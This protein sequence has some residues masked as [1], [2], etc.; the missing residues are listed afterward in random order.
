MDNINL[1]KNEIINMVDKKSDLFK[2]L[3]EFKKYI[4][5]VMERD[6][7]NIEV[8]Y[9]QDLANYMIEY[10]SQSLKKGYITN[11]NIYDCIKKSIH[12]SSNFYVITNPSIFADCS[13]VKIGFNFS[14]SFAI[15]NMKHV[16]FHELTHSIANL[17][18]QDLGKYKSKT[19]INTGNIKINNR[20]DNFVPI[21]SD[22]MIIFLD[23][24]MAESMACDLAETHKL[25]KTQV[26]P[27]IFSDWVVHYNRL[28]QNLGYE[29]L[30][31][32]LYDEAINEREL[33]KQFIINAINNH[34]ICSYILKIY[35]EKNPKTWKEDLHEVTTILGEIT[36]THLLEDNKIKRVRELME[37]YIPKNRITIIPRTD[38]NETQKITIHRRKF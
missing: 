19:N 18:N 36:S 15:A 2:I 22:D 27:G 1:Q 14:N 26:I 8:K 21:I 32:L 11:N 4:L 34:N 30:Q 38:T 13:E 5:Q 23:E 35:E 7:P 10:F 12:S 24:L 29:F 16:I 17:K 3:L 6:I 37:K 20:T 31:T 9:R 25:L 28:Y 33:F